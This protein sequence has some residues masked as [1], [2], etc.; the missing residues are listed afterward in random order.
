[1]KG[2][3]PPLP[4][5]NQNLNLARL[6]VSPHPLDHNYN[7]M[8]GR[9]F[10]LPPAVQSA[11]AALTGGSHDWLTPLTGRRPRRASDFP[12][13]PQRS[14]GVSSF[15]SRKGMF[16]GFLLPQAQRQETRYAGRRGPHIPRRVSGNPRQ[17]AARKQARGKPT[18]GARGPR[19]RAVRRGGQ[20]RL[21]RC[22]QRG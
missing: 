12:V 7:R 3:E 16:P 22:E 9:A 15:R 21:K 13:S 6:P 20:V 5:E 2:L 19:R 14:A 10:S 18:T 8:W 4:F 17:C 1:M 11:Y